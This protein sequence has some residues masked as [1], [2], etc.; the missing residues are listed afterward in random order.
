MFYSMDVGLA[1]NYEDGNVS[2]N[3]YSSLYTKQLGV[4]NELGSKMRRWSK[5]RIPNQIGHPFRRKS[6]TCSEANRPR[7][8]SKS[9]TPLGVG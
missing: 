9:A 3:V 7:L 5:V 6:A 1:W 4:L 2:T 8:R